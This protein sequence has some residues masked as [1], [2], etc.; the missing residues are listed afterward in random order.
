L[1]GQAGFSKSNK[2]LRSFSTT[3]NSHSKLQAFQR[4]MTSSESGF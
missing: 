4:L 1:Q 2:D 3:S